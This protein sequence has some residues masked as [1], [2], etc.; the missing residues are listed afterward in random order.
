[1]SPRNRTS[2]SAATTLPDRT[3]SLRKPSRDRPGASTYL[4]ASPAFSDTDRVELAKRGRVVELLNQ[5][6]ARKFVVRFV[7]APDTSPFRVSS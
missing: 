3:Y 6:Q 7:F 4:K 5:S 2:R 1:M